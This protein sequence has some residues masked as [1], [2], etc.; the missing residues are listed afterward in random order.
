MHRDSVDFKPYAVV[1]VIAFVVGFVGYI[2]VMQPPSGGVEFI[3]NPGLVA[4]AS[5]STATGPVSDAWN[6]EKS[7]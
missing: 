1:A 7:I 2:F 4:P 5:A 3:S 6:F